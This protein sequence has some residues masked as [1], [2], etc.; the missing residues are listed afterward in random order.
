[1]TYSLKDALR[2]VAHPRLA[3][4]ELERT[5]F[6]SV[7]S[8]IDEADCVDILSEDWDVLAILDACRYDTFADVIDLPGTLKKVRSKASATDQFLRENLDGRDA[9]D[10][11]YVTGN[12]QFYRIQNGIYHVDPI[13]C[14]FH[15]IVNV[16]KDNWDE[17][18]RTVRPE[19]ITDAAIE[20]AEEFPNKRVLIHY[21]QPHAPY[22][23]PTGREELPTD[24]LDFWKRFRLGEIDADLRVARKAYREN[25]ELVLNDVARLFDDIDGRIVLTAD[26]GE[27]LGEHSGLL[28]IKKY[29]HPAGIHTPELVE[30]PWFEHTRGPRRNVVAEE[31]TGSVQEDIANE[32]VEE[33]LRELGYVS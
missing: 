16:W 1:M 18:H 8:A 9:T 33:R 5:Y 31:P 28:P 15:K 6:S 23:G 3:A 25:L 2:A 7:S 30:I 32:T 12:P 20:A 26:H 24:V 11:V 10:I 21:L 4:N 29:G 22:I 27:M 13:D 17:E 14:Q 19:V